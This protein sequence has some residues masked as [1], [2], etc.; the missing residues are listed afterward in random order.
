LMRADE[1]HDFPL[2]PVAD[3]ID[4]AENDTEEDDLTAKPENFDD[5]PENEV[6]LEGH[7]ADERVAQHDRVDVD[8][9]AHDEKLART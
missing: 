9:P 4:L 6:R 2:R 1:Q 8:V 7:L 5:H 3:A